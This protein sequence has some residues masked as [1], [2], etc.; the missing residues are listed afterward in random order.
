MFEKTCSQMRHEM[1]DQID[2]LTAELV[3]KVRESGAGSVVK[4][5]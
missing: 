4:D 3:K 1:F 2:A 5:S